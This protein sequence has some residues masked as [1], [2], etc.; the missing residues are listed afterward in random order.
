MRGARSS[1]TLVAGLL[2]AVVVLGACSGNKQA[3]SGTTTT[4]A[5]SET[6]TTTE[7]PLSA[8]KQFSFYVPAV[9]DCF[10][11]RPVDNAAP[12]T[13]R[14]DCSLPHQSEVFAVFDYTDTKEYP[15]GQ[16][17]EAQ[18]KARCPASWEAYVG[19]PYETS[20]YELAYA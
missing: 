9:G 11:V 7:A 8:G 14:L 15:G 3:T 2:V 1:A 17:L 10:D 19:K 13:L 4:G 16:I 5:P 6:T 18:A 12:I 20:S